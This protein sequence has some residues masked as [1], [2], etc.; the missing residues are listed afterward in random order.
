MLAWPA[1]GQGMVVLGTSLSHRAAWPDQLAE[2][3]PGCGLD[4][5]TR[6]TRPGAGSDWGRDQLDAVAAAGPALVLIEFAINDAD[7]TDGLWL[8][9]SR[10]N[11][12]DIALGLREWLPE[13]RLVFLS[14]NAAHG[15]KGLLRPRL[16]RFY[17]MTAAVAAETGV[18]FVD[19]HQ[20]WRA[21][22]AR[23]AAIPDGLHPTDEGFAAIAL[24]PLTTALAGIMACEV[25]RAKP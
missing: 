20:V 18:D 3:L 1:A 7:I 5:V 14:M 16:G 15:L 10:Q 13:A 2:A 12:R 8:S 22:P 9:E 19:L 17:A 23:R 24:G 21:A 25:S 4:P 6:I 11:H